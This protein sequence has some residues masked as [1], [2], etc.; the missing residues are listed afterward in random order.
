MLGGGG[1]EKVLVD[2]VNLL[3]HN[4]YK[5]DVVSVTGGV[6]ESRLSPH[7]NYYKMIKTENKFLK[8]L[9]TRIFYHL[10]FCLVYKLVKKDEYDIEIAYLEGFPTHVI[11]AGKSRAKKLAFVHCDVSVHNITK[12]LYKNNIRC[13]KEYSIFNKVCFVSEAAKKGFEKTVGKLE[14]GIV[15]H[16]VIDFKKAKML[17]EEKNPYEYSTNGMK[18]ITVGR[19]SAEKGNERLVNVLSDLEKKYDFELWL[20]G[21]GDR[22]EAIEEIIEK[23]NM[24]SVKMM[25]FQKNPYSFMRKADLLV[26]PSYYEGYSTVVAEA[27]SLGLPV[28]TTDC[29]GMKEILDN[30]KSGIIV[31]NSEEGIKSGLTSLFEDEML[32]AKVKSHL[33][34]NKALFDNQT[35]VKEYNDLFK[36]II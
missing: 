29:A 31:E 34:N 35:T 24:K 36:E 19:L 8:K 30:G 21:D 22:R 15:I 17:S 5:V 20:L 11:A 4:K 9:L 1:A 27:V 6:H 16:N 26:C 12:R 18:L 25:G 28:L 14:N 23:N 13:L 7:V 32:Y 10:P 2:L 33:E 3:D